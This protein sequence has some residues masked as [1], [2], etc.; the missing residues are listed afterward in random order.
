[1][2]IIIIREQQHTLISRKYHNIANMNINI[3]T[4]LTLITSISLVILA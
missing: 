3:T 2:N 1:M 4:V